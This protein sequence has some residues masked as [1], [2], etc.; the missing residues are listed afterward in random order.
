MA[1]KASGQI[2]PEAVLI[3]GVMM[4]LLLAMFTVSEHLRQQ[5]DAER[6]SLQATAAATS[7][8]QA[9]NSVAASGNGTTLLYFNSAGSDVANMSIYQLRSLRAYYRE[10]GFVS[11]ALATNETNMTSPTIPLNVDLWL[12]NT[13]GTVYV[14]GA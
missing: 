10:G 9:I 1:N 5:W 14:S 3:A 12:N 4:F 7:L 8:A 2:A 13:G 6:Q 11:V